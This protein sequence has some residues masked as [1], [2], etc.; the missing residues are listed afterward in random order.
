MHPAHRRI[1]SALRNPL[2][3]VD[4]TPDEL[5]LTLRLTRRARLLGRLATAAERTGAL[6]HLPRIAVDQLRS[7]SVTAAA[8]ARIA[9]W[10]LNRLGR[11]LDA[12]PE[13]LLVAMKGTAYLLSGTPN[14][15]GRLFSDVD[16]LVPE[17]DLSRVER[18]LL[19]SGWV[20]KELTPYDDLYYRKWTHELPPLVHEEREVEVDLHHSIVMRTSRLVF[21]SDKLFERIRPVAGTRFAVLDPADMLLNAMVHLF[22]GGEM[23]EALRE[24]V[25]IADLFDHFGESEPDFHQ[26]F[27]ERAGEL[28]LGRPA[29]YGVRYAH[30]LL[31]AQVPEQLLR[32]SQAAAPAPAVLAMMDRL[33]RGAVFP[34]HPDEPDRSK[35]TA[36][37]ALYLRSHWVKMP[38]L[39]LCRHLFVKAIYRLKRAE[40]LP[41]PG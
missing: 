36:Q 25:D 35:D 6:A 3:L 23:T 41:Q 11:A 31:E 38:P 15:E 14:A 10:E 8:Q 27:W 18:R 34:P 12:L 2:V 13:V 7:A 4:A 9:R 32:V 1:L 20:G 28:G 29:F 22:Y 16:L 40:S 17:R 5:D 21:S 30:Q 19:E 39:M 33:V 24:L 37:F 26:A